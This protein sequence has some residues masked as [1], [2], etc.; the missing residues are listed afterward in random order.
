[1]ITNPPMDVTVC[2]GDAVNITCGY[3]GVDPSIIEPTWRISTANDGSSVLAVEAINADNDSGNDD[4]LVWIP[5]LTS[6]AT[7]TKL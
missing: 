7:V 6:I 3:I 1:M 4:G 2:I 5:D